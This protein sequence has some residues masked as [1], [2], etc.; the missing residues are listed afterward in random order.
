MK[1]T[2]DH[3]NAKEVLLKAY[4]ENENKLSFLDNEKIELIDNIITGN[5]LTF[6]YI[7]LTVLLA[8]ATNS[9]ANI[10][11]L[12]ASSN[13]NGAYDAR[14]LCHQVIV[15]FEREYFT[16]VLGGSNEPFLNKPARFPEL[17]ITNPV[18]G[19]GDSKKLND[20]CNIL[21]TISQT[22]AYN[23]LAVICQKLNLLKK[24][25]E[26]LL[27]TKINEKNNIKEIIDF[28]K[29]ISQIS[30]GGETIVLSIASIL[31]LY[32]SQYK[33]EYLV[34]VH[35]VNQSGASSKEVSDLD[36]YINK[37]LVLAIE[38]KDKTFNE[39]DVVHAIIKCQNEGHN[40]LDFIIGPSVKIT[41]NDEEKL[42]KLRNYYYDR[43]F[44]L[45]FFSLH[46][47]IELLGRKIIKNASIEEFLKFILKE[48]I[49]KKFKKTTIKYFVDNFKEYEWI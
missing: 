25:Q 47:Y 34:D 17:S 48:A 10:L 24:S 2:I 49:D 35:P 29:E 40:Q 8:K 11:A 18:R 14:S 9:N 5:H 46:R 45:E 3:K 31:N 28:I 12:Q 13:L 20:L 30:N 39:H 41:F 22:D 42:R 1:V 27:T 32:Y 21:P 44:F 38:L 19:G 43:G 15:P 37:E 4:N 6:K 16:S 26:S 33:I 23:M 7:F 36:I